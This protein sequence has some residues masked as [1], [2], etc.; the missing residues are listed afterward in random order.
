MSGGTKSKLCFS[1]VVCRT[2]QPFCLLDEVINRLNM[3]EEK[4]TNLFPWKPT[5]MTLSSERV[6][7]VASCCC[8]NVS[9]RL[10]QS[11]KVTLL[12]FST[13]NKIEHALKQQMKM[14]VKKEE[15][16]TGSKEVVKKINSSS[17]VPILT[18]LEQANSFMEDRLEHRCL[19]ETALKNLSSSCLL[20]KQKVKFSDFSSIFQSASTSMSASLATSTSSLNSGNSGIS[21]TSKPQSSSHSWPTAS[22]EQQ[23]NKKTAGGHHNRHHHH[24]QKQHALHTQHQHS[25]Q[26]LSSSSSGVAGNMPLPV[27]APGSTSKDVRSSSSNGSVPRKSKKEDC[28]NLWLNTPMFSDDS[29]S[30]PFHTGLDYLDSDNSI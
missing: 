14:K 15:G 30:S 18:R 8:S 3:S 24:Q 7:E 21:K 20:S 1:L 12:L 25:Q 5:S 9:I 16:N 6:R 22:S 2:P 4:L 10:P 26:R 17:C 23:S 29:S 11:G 13:L 27:K 19:K 28:D